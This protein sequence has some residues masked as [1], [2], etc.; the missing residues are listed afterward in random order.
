MTVTGSLGGVLRAADTGPKV[1]QSQEC[2]TFRIVSGAVHLT[3]STQ[4]S[5][6]R[7][8]DSSVS[9]AA[10]R[11]SYILTVAGIF[12]PCALNSDLSRSHTSEEPPPQHRHNTKHGRMHRFTGCPA[13]PVPAATLAAPQVRPPRRGPARVGGPPRAFRARLLL[14]E[15]RRAAAPDGT[16]RGGRPRA[17]SSTAAAAARSGRGV[18]VAT[19]GSPGVAHGNAPSPAGRGRRGRGRQRQRRRRRRLPPSLRGGGFRSPLLPLL[20]AAAVA[21]PTDSRCRSR[22]FGN[23]PVI[24]DFCFC[25]CRYM[26][27]HSSGWSE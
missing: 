25:E 21:V 20:Y 13:V 10:R 18:A 11:P 7:P 8:T 19:G 26:V 24:Q 17:R 5:L 9:P 14:A 15:S 1:R 4:H 27:R 2:S 3:P 16:A 6:A 23:S 12:V 22:A